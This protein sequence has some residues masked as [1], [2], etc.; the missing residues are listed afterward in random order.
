MVRLT[1][2][3]HVREFETPQAIGNDDDW[4]WS[5]KGKLEEAE[6][7]EDYLTKRAFEQKDKPVILRDPTK[8]EAMS[9]TPN[10]RHSNVTVISIT[11]EKTNFQ[12]RK[13]HQTF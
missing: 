11:P 13:K 2:Y 6:T 5:K 7:G 9:P 1:A 10:T 3:N 8:P 12:M 4:K